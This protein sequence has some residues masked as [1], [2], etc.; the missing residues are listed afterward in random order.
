MPWGLHPDVA[1]TAAYHEAGHAVVAEV[2]GIGCCAA[3]VGYE[4]PPGRHRYP[5]AGW[6]LFQSRTAPPVLTTSYLRRWTVATLA[7]PVAEARFAGW[8]NHG[9]GGDLEQ[10]RKSMETAA[11]QFGWS[12]G[13][14]AAFVNQAI[15]QTVE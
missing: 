14:A 7:G 1:I 3:A 6:T 4:R 15:E 11:P 10:V 2:L 9:A 5:R 13:T 12:D 8:D